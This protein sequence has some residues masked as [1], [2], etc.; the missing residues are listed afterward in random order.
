MT[1]LFNTMEP[2]TLRALYWATL[3]IIHLVVHKCYN[4]DTLKPQK[5][6][7]LFLG[8]RVAVYFGYIAGA[9]DLITVFQ[10]KPSLFFG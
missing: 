2:M 8:I 4:S 6:D 10:G 1:N 3:I 5:F 9:I 7:E